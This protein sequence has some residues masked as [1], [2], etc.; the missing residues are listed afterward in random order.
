VLHIDGEYQGEIHLLD[1]Y[2]CGCFVDGHRGEEAAYRLIP[3]RNG[4]FHFVRSNI[5]SNIKSVRST[6]EF[7]MEALRRHDEKA[8]L[9]ASH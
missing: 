2:I 6:T 9:P 1:G 5:R 3:V 7:M 8:K 4:R